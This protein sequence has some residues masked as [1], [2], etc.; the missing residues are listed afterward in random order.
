MRRRCGFVVICLSLI[1]LCVSEAIATVSNDDTVTLKIYFSDSG[2]DVSDAPLVN[3]AINAYIEPILGFR[4]EIEFLRD[5]NYSQ[6]V[7]Q[8][9]LSN[10]DFDILYCKSYSDMCYQSGEGWL[11]PLDDLVSEHAEA[12]SALFPEDFLRNIRIE[13]KLY[14]L[15]AYR[16]Q[17]SNYGVGYN[18]SIAQECGIDMSQVTSYKDLTQIF[19]SIREK[20]PDVI[21]YVDATMASWN[22]WDKLG[23]ELGVLMDINSAEVSNVYE[24]EEFLEFVQQMYAW[25]KAGYVLD[26]QSYSSTTADYLGSGQIFCSIYIGKPDIVSQEQRITGVNMGYVPLSA[27]VATTDNIDRS[28][29]AINASSR[30]PVQAMQFINMMYSDPALANLIVY[31]IEGLH[32]EFKNADRTVIGFPQGVTT[33][34]S[35]Y[36]KLISWQYCNETLTYAWEGASPD[37]WDE[38]E[39]FNRTAQ[40]SIAF[41]FRFDPAPVAA[42]V[43]ACRVAQSTY[44]NGLV[45]GQLDPE[46]YLPEFLDALEDAGIDEVISEKQRQLDEWLL[47]QN[48]TNGMS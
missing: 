14:G 5:Y 9:F 13:G 29:T 24:S 19:E 30:Y 23:D 1:L 34:S 8:K 36:A 47:S 12:F 37:I 3:D 39:E 48:A 22:S 21:P 35:H 45:Q 28:F 27:A 2:R 46:T 42:Q 17:A 6:T 38:L 10:E 7:A 25:N 31:G 44:R 18:L 26:I 16:E 15:P 32:Y 43:E 40:K 4:V 11:L 41:G 20:R 33:H